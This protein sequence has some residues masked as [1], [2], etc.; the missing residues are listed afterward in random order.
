MLKIQTKHT[1]FLLHALLFLIVASSTLTYWSVAEDA[2]NNWHPEYYISETYISRVPTWQ[3]LLKDGFAFLLLILS[4][5][6][7]PTNSINNLIF[8]KDK[9]LKVSYVLGL[10][11]LSVAFVRSVNSDFSL[12]IIISSLRPIFFTV[13]LFVFCER[14]LNYYYL[15]WVLEGVNVLAIIQV[16]YAFLQRQ[17][18]VIQYGAGWFSSGS[19]RSVGTFIGPNTLGLFLAIVFLA[20]LYILPWNKFRCILLLLCFYGIFLSDSRTS[21]LIAFLLILEFIFI[22]FLNKF[23]TSLKDFYFLQILITAFAILNITFLLD[24]I[25]NLSSRGSDSSASGGRLEILLSFIKNHDIFTILFGKSLGYGSNLV[26]TLQIGSNSLES[27]NFLADSTWASLL[28]QFGLV[29]VLFA[30]AITYF[31]LRLPQQNNIINLKRL[32]NIKNYFN[33]KKMGVL[34]Y[35]IPASSTIVLLETYAVLPILLAVLFAIRLQALCS[36]A[37]WSQPYQ[38]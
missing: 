13:S 15:I 16:F 23:K 18:S 8:L 30:I 2:L 36:I 32:N 10:F 25:K 3:K 37:Y 28:S 34:I 5:L 38:V 7:Y 35:L 33:I 29:G 22:K 9:S 19:V 27:N 20:N 14:H 4:I 17:S 6:L 1:W 12:S 26:S 24:Q 31:I 11:V 21:L